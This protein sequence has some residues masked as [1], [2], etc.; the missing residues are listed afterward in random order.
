M[1]YIIWVDGEDS[2]VLHVGP[3]ADPEAAYLGAALD[4]LEPVSDEDYL[5]G[6]A[7]IVSTA[8][9][10]SYVL[11]G[12][13]VLWCTEWEPGLLVFR[14][15]PDA[16]MQRVALRSPVPDFA[17]R[18]ASQ[19]A[20]EAWDEEAPNPQYRLIFDAWDAQFEADTRAWLGFTVAQPDDLRRWQ[21]AMSHV[22]GLHKS[23]D[24]RNSKREFSVAKARVAAW[25]GYGVTLWPDD[26][27]KP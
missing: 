23:L 25:A 24:G 21:T 27:E 2:A 22:N 13:D 26:I 12:E 16:T 8:A 7:V 14:F 15:R 3:V 18:E 11:D 10:S 4:H 5:A 20:I 17:G 9:R 19:E 6:P 1:Q